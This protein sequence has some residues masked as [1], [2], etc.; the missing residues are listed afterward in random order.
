M[1]Q[2]PENCCII[3]LGFSTLLSVT[4]V[5]GELSDL[6][7]TSEWDLDAQKD[8]N[9]VSSWTVVFAHQTLWLKGLGSSSASQQPRG[10]VRE[11]P[12]QVKEQKYISYNQIST[13]SIL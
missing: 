7:G 6:K 3:F 2:M 10:N 11:T 8:L 1:I 4:C 9:H 5:H 12:L 13:L